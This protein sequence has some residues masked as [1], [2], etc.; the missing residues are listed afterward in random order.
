MMM[1]TL[2]MTLA[3]AI[4]AA[5]MSAAQ[6]LQDDTAAA[7]GPRWVEVESGTSPSA[8]HENAAAAIDGRL[9]LVGGR[10]DRAL[11]IY[12][13]A[14]DEWT[15]GAA[16]GIEIH[17]AQAVAHEG[18]LYVI[19]ALT[20]AFPQE[21]A[22][23]HITVYDPRIDEWTIET[24]IPIHR[25]RGSAGVLVHDGVFYLFGGTTRGHMGGFTPWADAF[26]PATG[27]WRELPDAPHA[28][29]HFQ[30]AALDG[31]IYLAG[32]R[33]SSHE[34]GEVDTLSV[35]EVDV[36]DPAS[37][38]WTTL[39][40]PLPTPRSGTTTVAAGGLIIVIGGESGEQEIAHNEVEAWSPASGEWVTLSPLPV[41]RHGTQAA[42]IGDNVHIAVGSGNRGGGPE[43]DDHW[44][45][46]GL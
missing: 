30:A 25:R 40:Q 24:P 46:T 26:D 31:R 9:Y 7:S 33:T 41:G 5:S 13:P 42:V 23:P 28:R 21:P 36:F 38:S 45:L 3:S 17:H 32:G 4:I 18:R 19:G 14:T 20:S 37:E 35:A 34:T 8:R 12:D 11:E 44:V 43:L 39:D 27:E 10:G 15:T 16:P 1:T 22:I 29:D 2:K 6:A